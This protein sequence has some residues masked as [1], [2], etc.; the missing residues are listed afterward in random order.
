MP[1]FA[2]RFTLLPWLQCLL[3]LTSASARRADGASSLAPP[4]RSWHRHTSCSPCASVTLRNR[5]AISI[6]VVVRSSSWPWRP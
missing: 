6:P 2:Y 1:S 5:T 3:V 4:R